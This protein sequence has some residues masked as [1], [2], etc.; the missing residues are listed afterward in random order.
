MMRSRQGSNSG[1]EH[2][3]TLSFDTLGLVV[4]F[5]LTPAIAWWEGLKARNRASREADE[6]GK[7]VEIIKFVSRC[8]GCAADFSH[9]SIVEREDVCRRVCMMCRTE[10]ACG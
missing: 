8:P 4:E 9:I 10:F 7:P 2:T 3:A 5:P 6:F 1:R